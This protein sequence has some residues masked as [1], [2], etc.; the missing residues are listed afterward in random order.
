MAK[1]AEFR[2]AGCSLLKGS[3]LP[4]LHQTGSVYP[5]C[6]T[7]TLVWGCGRHAF[8]V[9]LLALADWGRVHTRRGK[10]ALCLFSNGLLL[11]S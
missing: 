9:S 3:D 1:T 2:N 7:I 8:S 10:Q 5:S 4:I 6:Q 11:G